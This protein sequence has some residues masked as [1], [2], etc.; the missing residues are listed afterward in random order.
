MVN[1]NERLVDVL[2]SLY[3]HRRLISNV[4]LFTLLGSLV[5]AFLLPNYYQSTTIFYPTSPQLAN[6]ELL[7]GSSGQVTQYYGNDNDLDRLLEIASG[8]ELADF[9]IDSFKLY[10]HYDID[11]NTAEGPYKVRKRFRKLYRVE[12][13]KFDAIEISIEDTDRELAA[14][15]INAARVKID[16]IGQRLTKDSQRKL[17]DAFERNI[18]GK[19]NTI[20]VLNDSI[21]VLKN[22]YGIYDIGS[23]GEQL[24]EISSTSRAFVAQYRAKLQSLEKEP[25]IPRATIAYVRAQLRGYDSQLAS[26]TTDDEAASRAAASNSANSDSRD[27]RRDPETSSGRLNPS[28]L[29]FVAAGSQRKISGSQRGPRNPAF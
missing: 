14:K 8:N 9:M 27:A 22:K 18:S 10:E 28:I 16:Q 1:N 26:L 23:Q 11:P 4:C 20:L 25:S 15:M 6:P 7:F 24:S 17:L 3:A 2:K 21:E 29:K 12:K 19:E 5:I 13:N